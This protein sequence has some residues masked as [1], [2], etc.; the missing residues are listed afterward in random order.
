[1][2]AAGRAVVEVVRAG[3]AMRPSTGEWYRR[4]QAELSIESSLE[5]VEA[6]YADTA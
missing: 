1:M 3:E 4:H 5:A 2:G 6:A